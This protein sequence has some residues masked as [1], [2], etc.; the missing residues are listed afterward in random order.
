M[1]LR[2]ECSGLSFARREHENLAQGFNSISANLLDL[3]SG[4]CSPGRALPGIEDEFEEGLR[5]RIEELKHDCEQRETGQRGL[6]FSPRTS[7]NRFRISIV[8]VLEL[9]LVR[10]KL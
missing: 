3:R 2:Q 9:V 6:D 1:A 10:G 8:I 7:K 4:R 5:W